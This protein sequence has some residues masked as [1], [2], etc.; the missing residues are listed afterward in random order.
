MNVRAAVT[1]VAGMFVCGVRAQ[2]PMPQQNLEETLP[3]PPREEVRR[4]R[5][6]RHDDAVDRLRRTVGVRHRAVEAIRRCEQHRVDEAV[7][8]M[9]AAF[10]GEVAARARKC[11]P[12]SQR[13]KSAS[14]VLD[15]MAVATMLTTAQIAM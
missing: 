14:R 3:E 7:A 4:D 9:R 6:E 8:R 1:L 10:F 2:T 15:S 5:G 11:A 13:A 12:G